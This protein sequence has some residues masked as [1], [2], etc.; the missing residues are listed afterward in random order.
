M[1]IVTKI[2][3]LPPGPR[4]NFTGILGH[5]FRFINGRLTLRG[6]L[7]WV[8]R[9][10]KRLVRDYKC[11]IEEANHGQRHHAAPKEHQDAESPVFGEVQP[12]G[13]GTAEEAPADGA[14][15]VEAGQGDARVR[16]EGDGH[17][18]P[19]LHRI[20]K[21]LGQ[22]DPAKDKFWTVEGLPKVSAVAR[23]SRLKDVSRHEIERA[24][25]GFIRGGKSHADGRC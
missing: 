11:S 12:G 14:A 17:E 4:E 16:S 10:F 15:G 8:D 18:D 25:P 5:K 6:D 13:P 9:I 24:A 23:R 20:R 1:P 22:L 2:A 19:R 3:I 7:E 21:A